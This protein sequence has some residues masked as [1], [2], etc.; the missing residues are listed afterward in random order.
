[1]GSYGLLFLAFIAVVVVV[2]NV[3]AVRR[4]NTRE[5]DTRAFASLHGFRDEGHANP[6]LGLVVHRPDTTGGVELGGVQVG[7]APIAP[8]MLI[9]LAAGLGTV[10]NVLGGETAAGETVLF[11]YRPPPTGGGH[12][13]STLFSA[14]AGFRVPGVPEF[15]LTLRSRFVFGIPLIEFSSHPRFSK[16]FML[17]AND[18]AAIRR[19]FSPAVLDAAEALSEK[20]GWLLQA[21]S[22]WLLVSP[23]TTRPEELPAFVEQSAR[24]AAAVQASTQPGDAPG[25]RPPS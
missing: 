20:R 12:S 11:D 14:V 3:L 23:G 21:G 16:R 13:G 17:M 7:R 5:Q 25:V 15:Q 8:Q 24:V 9:E 10:R 6:F 19:A 18:E 2:A 4:R 22:G 1:M